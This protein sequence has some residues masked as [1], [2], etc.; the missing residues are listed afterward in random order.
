MSILIVFYSRSGRTRLVAEEL[1][2]RLA[3]ET[4]EITPEKDYKGS[5]GYIRGGYEAARKKTTPIRDPGKDPS[6]FDHLL[7]GTPV[8]AA[9]MA[10]PVRTFIEEHADSLGDVSFFVTMGGSGDRKALAALEDA[11]GRKPKATLALGA[12]YLD[13]SRAVKE[14]G[15]KL[16][17]GF[18][19]KVGPASGKG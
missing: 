16:I 4:L 5:V 8:W 19:K 3:A 10:P 13:G 12:K 18:V 6:A 11:A 2:S 7:I 15:M 17:E 1:A 14:E 9:N